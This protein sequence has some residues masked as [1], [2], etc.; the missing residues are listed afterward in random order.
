[1]GVVIGCAADNCDERIFNATSSSSP[2]RIRHNDNQHLVLGAMEP[3]RQ[4]ACHR[5]R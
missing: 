2:P 3:N 1:M 4:L 5:R